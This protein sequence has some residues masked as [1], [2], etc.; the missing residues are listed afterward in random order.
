MSPAHQQLC[1]ASPVRDYAAPLRHL[2][3]LRALPMSGQPPFLSEGVKVEPIVGEIVVGDARPG[4]SLEV[5]GKQKRV[6][7]DVGINMRLGRVDRTTS[8][9]EPL[10]SRTRIYR[11]VR[12]GEVHDLRFGRIYRPGVYR[13][14][15]VFRRP[16]GKLL[17]KYGQYI[18]V[19]RA[20]RDARLV[21]EPTMARLGETVH[22]HL[23]NYGTLPLAFGL[24]YQV[25]VLEDGGW[26]IAEGSPTGPWPEVQSFLGSGAA[27][28]CDAWRVPT[29]EAVGLYR[30]SHRVSVGGRSEMLRATFRVGG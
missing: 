13:L 30:M 25:E 22:G 26:R 11:I 17:G 6:Q 3:P 7:L 18:R 8:G 21:V 15:V 4:L 19:V 27:G 24:P 16:D 1:S 5:S 2:K 23:A 28:G 29:T 9:V 20:T 14:M 10:E 12:R